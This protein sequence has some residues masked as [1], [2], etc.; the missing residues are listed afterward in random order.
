MSLNSLTNRRFGSRSRGGAKL[1]M[2][3]VVSVSRAMHEKQPLPQKGNVALTPLR[4]SE[5][6]QFS[7]SSRMNPALS[8]ANTKSGKPE[9]LPSALST[10][11]RNFLSFYRKNPTNNRSPVDV[12]AHLMREACMDYSK[13]IECLADIPCPRKV[14]S[15][16]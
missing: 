7:L 6:A 12:L 5:N 8:N 10:A 9:H 15:K 13:T 1:V 14:L 2:A 3:D 4:N 16:M 11:V